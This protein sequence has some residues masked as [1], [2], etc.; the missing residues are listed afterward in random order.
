M[1]DTTTDDDASQEIEDEQQVPPHVGELLEVVDDLIL[2]VR[3]AK[4][5]PLSG[6][7]L[8]DREQTLAMLE[9]LKDSLPDELR[10]A[11]WMV[12]EREAFITRTNEKARVIVER[13]QARSKDLVSES[14]VLAEAVEEANALVRRAE[15]EARRIRLEAEDVAD[16]RLEHLEVLFTNLLRQIRDA[17]GE[18]HTARPAPPE[19]PVSE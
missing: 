18:F 6:N 12:R 17:R 8:I 3:E 13:A 16:E 5:V 4:A 19:V 9:Q 1:S 11:R 14:H 2:A 15:G 7:V 10:A